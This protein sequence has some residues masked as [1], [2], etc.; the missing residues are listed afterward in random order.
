MSSH[1][2]RQ[3]GRAL[4]VNTENGIRALEAALTEAVRST[5]QAASTPVPGQIPWTNVTGK[6]S[7]FA[8]NAADDV[9]G[10][11]LAD[12]ADDSAAATGGIEIGGLYR[13]GSVVMV[14]V[15]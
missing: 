5:P 12:H 13:N 14:R 10:S 2:A 6:P 7:T 4:G 3:L 9:D 1:A 11:T 15:S 8:S